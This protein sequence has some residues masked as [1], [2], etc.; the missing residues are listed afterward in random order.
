MPQAIPVKASAQR[1]KML[2]PLLRAAIEREI[3]Q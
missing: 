3:R 1:S 2:K